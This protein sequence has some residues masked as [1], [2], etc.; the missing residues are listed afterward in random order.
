MNKLVFICMGIVCLG[1][2]AAYFSM[3]SAPTSDPEL[4]ACTLEAK[5]CPDGSFVGRQGPQCE[6]TACPPAGV[7]LNQ[8]ITFGDT[9]ITPLSIVEDSRCPV[10]AQ[11]IW[12]GT[13]VSEVKITNSDQEETRQMSIGDEVKTSIGSVVLD[14]VEPQPTE[15][16]TTEEYTF[17]FLEI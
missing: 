7:D 10:D 5:Q 15:G 11:C 13:F 8:T 4:I 1:A 9:T 6:F 3:D 2:V 17:L 16:T 14:S 12:A